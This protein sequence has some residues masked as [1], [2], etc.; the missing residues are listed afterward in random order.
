VFDAVHIGKRT[1][2]ENLGHGSDLSRRRMPN[3]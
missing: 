3:P 2:N 1:G